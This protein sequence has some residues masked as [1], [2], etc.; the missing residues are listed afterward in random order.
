MVNASNTVHDAQA[1]RASVHRRMTNHRGSATPSMQSATK[2]KT[3]IQEVK[4]MTDIPSIYKNR[5]DQ[6]Y[7]SDDE[8]SCYI[9]KFQV[10]Y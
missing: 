8:Y 7:E 10:D 5:N 6:M 9:R 1:A 4:D 3:L 2:R